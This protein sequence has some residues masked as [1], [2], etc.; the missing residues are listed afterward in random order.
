MTLISRTCCHFGGVQLPVQS[1]SPMEILL[2]LANA[3]AKDQW[4]ISAKMV[5]SPETRELLV[6]LVLAFGF[7]LGGSKDPDADAKWMA[8]LK[9]YGYTAKH[10]K[11]KVEHG[12]FTT[13]ELGTPN[14]RILNPEDEPEYITADQP[15]Y[16][17]MLKRL[18]S[19]QSGTDTIDMEMAGRGDTVREV[20]DQSRSIKKSEIQTTV[21]PKPHLRANRWEK[22]RKRSSIERR[23]KEAMETDA[24]DG[25]SF[26]PDI[27]VYSGARPFQNRVANLN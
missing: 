7:C 3:L 21:K 12:E 9:Q 4:S 14:Y 2:D 24:A 10:L 11:N 26:I 15:H 13:F 16:Q 27:Q 5:G 17:E 23:F 8:P 1:T 18:T 25:R 20:P 22:L 6:I 19:A